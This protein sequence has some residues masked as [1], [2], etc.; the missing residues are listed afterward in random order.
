MDVLV[1]DFKKCL[2][3]IKM[4]GTLKIMKQTQT[5]GFKYRTCVSV[6]NQ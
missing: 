1:C 2:N 3:A 5:F 4:K 6:F